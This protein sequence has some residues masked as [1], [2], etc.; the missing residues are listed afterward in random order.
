MS[1]GVLFLWVG[2]TIG[3]LFE[4]V[5]PYK[6]FEASSPLPAAGFSTGR[7]VDFIEAQ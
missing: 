1:D 3:S 7:K 5:L 4:D 6:V 2:Q